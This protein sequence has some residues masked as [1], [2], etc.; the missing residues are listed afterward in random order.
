M[1][2]AALNPSYAPRHRRLPNSPKQFFLK[3]PEIAVSRRRFGLFYHADSI[4]FAK[5]PVSQITGNRTAK[6]PGISH[7]KYFTGYALRIKTF[8]GS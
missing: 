3:F 1:S 8:A 7:T 5:F 2:F 4:T 6:Y